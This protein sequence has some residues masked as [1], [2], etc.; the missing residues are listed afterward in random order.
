MALSG[1]AWRAGVVVVGVAAALVNGCSGGEE[2]VRSP[3]TVEDLGPGDWA[4]PF[5]DVEEA[6][7]EHRASRCTA[8]RPFFLSDEGGG[9]TAEELSAW[10]QAEMLVT[11]QVD[12][13]RPGDLDLRGRLGTPELLDDCVGVVDSGPDPLLAEFSWAQDGDVVATEEVSRSGTTQ[14]HIETAMT[15]TEDAFVAVQV[16]WPE[17]GAAGPDAR[18]LLDRAVAGVEASSAPEAEEE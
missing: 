3:L 12:W 18:E 13:Y 9:I 17:D 15:A 14:Y 7:V 10:S 1:A 8:L 16:S 2:P 4:G 5:A 11:V 6:E